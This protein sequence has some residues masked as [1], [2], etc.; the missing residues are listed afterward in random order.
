[1]ANGGRPRPPDSG[2]EWLVLL[3]VGAVV[4]LVDQVSKAIIMATV[5]IG[6][7]VPVLGDL[8]QIWHVR[9]AGAA[10]SLFQGAD[11]LFYVVT[12]AALVMIAYFH[13]SL[14]GRGLW[15]HALLGLMLGGALGNFVDRIRLGDVTDFVSV[16]VGELRWPTFNVADASLVI[17]IG[18]L[19]AYFTFR[20]ETREAALA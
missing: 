5:Q 12:I 18:V 17:A 19:V 10:F 3:G 9:N 8:V 15:L 7:R 13:R 6:Q 4:L 2:R 11:A 1:M 14:R 16:G 20:D